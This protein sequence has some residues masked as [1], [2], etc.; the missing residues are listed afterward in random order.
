MVA[1]VQP[2]TLG[3]FAMTSSVPTF[4]YNHVEEVANVTRADI[5]ALTW[6]GSRL[7]RYSRL[8]VTIG[9]AAEYP[10][11]YADVHLV[12]Y[13]GYGEN[14]SYVQLVAGLAHGNYSVTERQDLIE[15]KV[16]EA[17]VTE[18]NNHA[19]LPFLPQLLENSTDFVTLYHQSDAYI[20]A[21]LPEIQT[22]GCPD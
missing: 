12:S 20:F 7:P 11:E 5:S 19:F 22:S 4:H 10:P 3:A 13:V 15:L 1:L 17:F 18:Q 14:A 21:F 8:L 16:T 2:L 6:A 9:S